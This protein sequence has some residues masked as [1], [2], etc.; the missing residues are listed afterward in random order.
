MKTSIT[1]ALI[2]LLVSCSK[3]KDSVTTDSGNNTYTYILNFEMENDHNGIYRIQSSTDNLN[4]TTIDS[5]PY[6]LSNNGIYSKELI[7]KKGSFLRVV[8]TDSSNTTIISDV[9]VANN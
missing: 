7:L 5:L 3:S 2:L 1:I 6:N 9:V 8:E 4:Y